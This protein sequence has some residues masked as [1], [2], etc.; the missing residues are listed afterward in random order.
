MEKIRIK[1]YPMQNPMPVVLV[2]AEVD[3]KPNYATVGAFGVVCLE[4]VFYI[5]LKD[6][7]Y[8]TAGVRESGFFSVNIPSPGLVQV[9]DCCGMVSGRKMDKTGL[10]TAFYDEQGKAPMI[11]ECPMNFLCKVIKSVPLYGF[12]MFYGEILA[13]YANE[14]CF[15]E[16]RPDPGKVN[17]LL[18]MGTGYY[19]LG[20]RVGSVFKDGRA[21]KPD[22]I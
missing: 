8:T 5:S 10:F 11:R 13:S 2:G 6:S 12:E 15:T 3:G 19:E 16:E 4:P 22:G 9:T 20:P 1:N 7:H 14:D 17:P 21:M 18:I